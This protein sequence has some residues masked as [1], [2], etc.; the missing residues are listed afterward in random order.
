MTL[1]V[2]HAADGYEY[3][4]RQVAT[5]DRER[6]RGGELT[7]YYTAHGT[8]PGEWWGGFG[9]D[10]LNDVLDD[11]HADSAD[12]ISAGDEVTEAQMKA[13]FGEGLH[14][15]A[16]DL[17]EELQLR[18]VPAE[19]AIRLARLGR[20]FPTFKNNVELFE[21]HAAERAEFTDTNGRAPPTAE[22]S[23]AILDRIAGGMFQ[24]THGRPVAN[25][26]ELR[27]WIAHEKGKVRHPVA[28]QDLVFTPPPKS[29]SSLWA[30]APNELRLEIERI[31]DQT[32]KDTLTWLE[33]NACFTRVGLRSEEQIDT[34]GFV[35]TL[36]KHFDSRAGD[37]NLHTHAVVSIKTQA[38]EDGKWRAVDG[39]TLFRFAV[40]ASQR[41][42]AEV[43][44]KLNTELGLELTTREVEQ[45]KQAV[46]ELAAIPSDMLEMFSSRRT[47]IEARRDELVADYRAKYQRMPSAKVMYQLYQQATLD[48]REG[49]ADPKSLAE[50]RAVWRDRAAEILGGTEAVD[51]LVR[52]AFTADHSAE[53]Q[54]RSLDDDA[55]AVLAKLESKRSR[56]QLPPHVLSAAQAH[57]AGEQF[58]SIDTYRAAIDRLTERV[59]ELSVTTP[60]RPELPAI[61]R[62]LRRRDGE[63]I[64]SHHAPTSTARRP[65][66][67]PKR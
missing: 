62:R 17:I 61:P 65:C 39:S 64:L 53:P 31:V 13:L 27:N 54:H 32:V 38:S 14:P 11:L 52:D 40:A 16:D 3:L 48:T 20:K 55:R 12:K 37:P 9:L 22:E 58:P 33:R 63:F 41:F 45:G 66:S 6:E 21:R 7:D 10:G 26:A 51:Q 49:K 28:G 30:V 50:M 29:V 56:W 8:P 34:N 18:G 25:E 5:A 42:N 2:L 15:N 59:L 36:Y 35:A 19:E 67:T 43:M 44:Q 57:L 60:P 24:E 46:V 47:A 23:A 1:H 4:T